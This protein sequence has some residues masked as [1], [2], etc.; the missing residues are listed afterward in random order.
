MVQLYSLRDIVSTRITH[1]DKGE[2]AGN[3]LA[4]TTKW[5]LK[6]KHTNIQI[7][8]STLYL[9]ALFPKRGDRA[10]ERHW[11]TRIIYCT[12]E[13]EE[14]ILAHSLKTSKKL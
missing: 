13:S 2:I 10:Q 14:S 11:C 9:H 7:T 1:A 5:P 3:R 6:S 12:L 8:T 4:I